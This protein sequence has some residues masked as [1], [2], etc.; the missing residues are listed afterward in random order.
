MRTPGFEAFRNSPGEYRNA[1]T[2][3]SAGCTIQVYV[4]DRQENPDPHRRAA[5][6]LVVRQACDLDNLSIGRGD[7]QARSGRARSAAGRGKSTR[8][9]IAARRA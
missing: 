2:R 4:E 7:Q 3:D 9:G 6:E 8:S 1:M 5:D